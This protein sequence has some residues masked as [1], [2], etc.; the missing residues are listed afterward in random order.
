M[1]AQVVATK[2]MVELT[3]ATLEPGTIDV[4][5]FAERAV[6]RRDHPL[7][8]RRVTRAARH[9]RSRASARQQLLDGARLRV[10]ASPT[11][12]ST[13]TVPPFRRYDV[14]RE[15]D[16]VEEVGRFD[17]DRPAR[18]RCPS[19]AT[20]PGRM[21]A[22]QRLRRRALDALVG[23]GAYE[24][25]GWSFTDRGVADR[26]RLPDDDPRRDFVALDNPM[27]ED[28]SVLRT[29]L[30]GSLLDVARHNVARGDTDLVLAEQGAVY[31]LPLDPLPHE[32]RALG[33]LVHGRLHAAELAQ[34]G[35]P[36]AADFFA[37]KGLLERRARH[38]ARRVGGRGRAPSRSCTP[39]AAPACSLAATRSA[40]SASCTRSSRAS[41]TS[42]APSA[43][44]EIDLDAVVAK[45]VAVPVLPRPDEL[46][47]GP[48]GH[49]GRRRATT[50]P[51]PTCWPPCAAPAASCS[52]EARVFDVYRGAQ[53]G[54]GRTSL[55]LALAFQAPDRT[56]SDED[57]AP[58][59]AQDRQGARRAG[60]RRAAWLASSS[61]A[62]PATPARSPRG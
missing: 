56:L 52:R 51:R 11:T 58:V 48:A 29:T 30:A 45:A 55:A 44:F 36:P 26:L 46:P 2:L 54:E 39:G 34:R 14:T 13:S 22:A 5:P 4:G 3:G 38:A 41:G 8:A 50:S 40:G 7:R 53:V 25:V 19:A 37:V 15:A 42:R 12:A 60:G 18:R 28:Q 62:R 16:L 17:L 61:P 57:V 31:A 23:R 6:A 33:A 47:G 59:R 21:S 24:V 35:S 10:R 1:D 49:R 9:G 27:S 20:P 32:H 43:I